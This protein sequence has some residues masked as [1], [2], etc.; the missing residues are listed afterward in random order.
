MSSKTPHEHHQTRD[1]VLSDRERHYLGLVARGQHPS[2][3]ALITGADE[4]EV[5]ETLERVR[6]RLGAANLLN[7][8]SIALLRGL[9]EH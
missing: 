5:K 8:V 9:I 4:T 2:H 7:A 3:V 1:I 6:Q